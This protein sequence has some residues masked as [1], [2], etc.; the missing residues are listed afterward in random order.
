MMAMIDNCPSG[1]LTYR[2]TADGPDVE[3]DLPAGIAVT[4][5]GPYFVTGA[6]PLERSDGEPF[7]ARPRMTLCRCGESSNKPLC[8]GTHKKTG[9]RD[10]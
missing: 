1:A 10:S 7:E 4:A 9:F 2:L 3:H 8:D 5:D 6:I